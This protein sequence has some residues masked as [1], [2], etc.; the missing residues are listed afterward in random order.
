MIS[1]VG[2]RPCLIVRRDVRT[3]LC[4]VCGSNRFRPPPKV[5]QIV[6]TA[7]LIYKS[8]T[9]SPTMRI[10]PLILLVAG[11]AGAGASL[12]AKQAYLEQTPDAGAKGAEDDAPGELEVTADIEGLNSGIPTIHPGKN[13]QPG[14]QSP[15]SGRRRLGD[16]PI[17][18][19]SGKSTR[20]ATKQLQPSTQLQSQWPTA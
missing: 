13:G 18:R 5:V 4:K 17:A 15:G 19:A 1:P 20:S 2:I 9:V 7:A 11:G 16:G 6:H 8:S 10:A 12:P 14:Q 3:Y